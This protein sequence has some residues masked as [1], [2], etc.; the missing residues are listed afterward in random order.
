MIEYILGTLFWSIFT[1]F[2]YAIGNVLIEQ[3]KCQAY[4]FVAGYVLYTVVMAIPAIVVQFFNFPWVVYEAYMLFMILIFIGLIIWHKK[5][6]GYFFSCNICEFLKDNFMVIVVCMALA[7]MLFFYFRMFWEGNHLDDGYY[8]TKVATLPE[9]ETGFRTNYAVGVQSS[10]VDSYVLNTWELEASVF[11]HLLGVHATLYLRLFQSIF[12]YL[13]CLNCILAFSSKLVSNLSK[14]VSSF[15]AQFPVG[16]MLL[17]FLYDLFAEGT[18]IFYVSDM[19]QNNTAM[20]YGG[21]LVK[22]ISIIILLLFYI[23]EKNISLKM[24]FGVIG[25]SVALI[26]RSTIALPIIVLV[27]SSYLVVTLVLSEKRKNQILAAFYLLLYCFA[28]VVLKNGAAQQIALYNLTGKTIKS[29]LVLLCCLIFVLG[30]FLL[31]ERILVKVNCIFL[32]TACFM[33]VPQLN[34]VFEL[35][36]V[37]GFVA[38]RAWDTLIYTFV[39]INMIYLYLLIR[40]YLKEKIAE[41]FFLVAFCG[42]V[43]IQVWGYDTYGGD[44]YINENS[45][46][47]ADTKGAIKTIIDNHYFFPNTTLELSRE[48]EKLYKETGKILQVVSPEVVGVNNAF[49]TLSVQLRIYAPDIISVSAADRYPIVDENTGLQGYTQDAYENFMLD[50]ND[51]TA[52]EFSEMIDKYGVNCIVTTN[53]DQE[54]YLTNM[55]FVKYKNVGNCYYIWYKE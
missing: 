51:E 1:V 3:D 48:L 5:K 16:A 20:Y 2:I 47:E 46:V 40:M 33:F 49:H 18:N 43:G 4:K 7:F 8:V 21:A 32:L 55:G 6:K 37:Y 10:V 24:I 42:L 12:H 38:G 22:V 31:R 54:S 25:I 39:I 36:C 27:A 52:K 41:G 28:G 50:P 53:Q 44:I 45:P 29:Y 13:V 34:D 26:S 11:V 35:F 23:E 15:E 30:A 17:L 14:N 19:T 9:L